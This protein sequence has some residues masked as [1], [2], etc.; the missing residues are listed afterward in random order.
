MNT[1]TQMITPDRSPPSL[2]PAN[3]Q[4]GFTVVLPIF[5]FLFATTLLPAY[6]QIHRFG[7]L[8]FANGEDESF[9]LGA[10]A[11]KRLAGL[12]RPSL[13]AVR[14]L[15]SAGL[16][17]SV[18]NILF[19]SA[20]VGT[21][22]FAV[23]AIFRRLAP[24]RPSTTHALALFLALAT[25]ILLGTSNPIHNAVANAIRA[26]DSLSWLIVYNASGHPVILRSPES[27]F[28][29]AMVGLATAYASRRPGRRQRWAPLV[30][31]LPILY[32]YVSSIVAVVGLV[33]F[34]ADYLQ[35][36]RGLRPA[37][38]V[39]IAGLFA[40]F[41]SALG[42]AVMASLFVPTH[43]IVFSHG[44]IVG[45]T[46]IYLLAATGLGASLFGWS[47]LPANLRLLIISILASSVVALNTQLVNGIVIQ[48]Q[49]FEMDGAMWSGII[50][51]VFLLLSNERSRRH[52]RMTFMSI[53]IV[54][55]LAL[56]QY[57][58][59]VT[60]SNN[61]L[62]SPLATL[63][64]TSD[65]SV[66][67]AE[68]PSRV[69]VNDALLS[70]AIAGL[71]LDHAEP[72]LTGVEPVFLSDQNALVSLL[73]FEQYLHTA[74]VKS[75]RVFAPTIGWLKLRYADGCENFLPLAV[76]RRGTVSLHDIP[77]VSPVDDTLDDHRYY[78]YAVPQP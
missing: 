32:F 69:A 62:A 1:A 36:I 40:L 43:H 66:R 21:F 49:H 77:S 7:F 34:A 28:S 44:P 59:T 64:Q 19:D 51:G 26:S 68:S 73:R 2:L 57:F 76:Q 38:A 8:I 30:L 54:L 13:Y 56:A 71:Y 45:L 41:V 67:L 14:W 65:I 16:T 55:T 48:P 17:G 53:V 3:P 75:A 29:I 60:A 52:E 22:G 39:L 50:L 37:P 35:R 15:H 5:L 58:R 72:L 78:Y 61:A 31:A 46:P 10:E 63:L 4:R 12:V 18:I 11:A 9:Y 33:Y 70:M 27:Q 42:I 6:L 74:D 24:A 25:P 47:H 20:S 23:G